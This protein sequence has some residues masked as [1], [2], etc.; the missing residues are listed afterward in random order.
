MLPIGML[1]KGGDDVG[2]ILQTATRTSMIYFLQA[3]QINDSM[4]ELTYQMLLDR[5]RDIK[6]P[7]VTMLG[8]G[9]RRLSARKIS[10]MSKPGTLS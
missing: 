10:T 8:V 3:R 4:P 5:L 6:N 7:K 2:L 1:Q 9:G